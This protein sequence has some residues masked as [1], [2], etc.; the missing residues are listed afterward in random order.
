M[1][2]G[3]RA[4]KSGALVGA[5]SNYI[6]SEA[7]ESLRQAIAEAGGTEVFA[8]GRCDRDFIVTE[9]SV[10]AR[11]NLTA[12]PVVDA[13]LMHG[14]V[15]IHNHPSGKLLPSEADL[16]VAA[17]L[18]ARGVGFWIVNN[19]VSQI[20]SVTDPLA[21]QAGSIVIDPADI[22]HIFSLDG[23]LSAA[24]ED[25][26]VR[27]GQ[28]DMA[29]AVSSAF[30]DSACLVVEAGTGTGKSLAY[31]VP[32]FLWAKRNNARVVVS[33]NTINLQEQLIQKDIPALEAAIGEPLPAALVKGRGNYLCMRKLNRVLEDEESSIEPEYRDGFAQ[34]LQWAMETETGDRSDMQFEPD[35]EVWGMVCSEGDMC[36]RTKCPNY[37]Q[38]CFHRARQAMEKAEVLVVNHHILFADAFIRSQMGPE[39]DRA[40]LPRYNVVIVDE[41]HNAADVAT[42]H[43]GRRVSRVSLVRLT[44]S[45]YRR[46][47]AAAQSV[48]TASTGDYGALVR[49]RSSLYSSWPGESGRAR[50]EACLDLIHIDAIPA[51]IRVREAG[52]AFFDEVRRMLMDVPGD[53]VERTLRITGDVK[54]REDWDARIFPAHERFAAAL[55]GLAD[56][57]ERLSVLLRGDDDEALLES[58][59]RLTFEAESGSGVAADEDGV[60]LGPGF[61]EADFP[62]IVELAAYAGRAREFASSLRFAVTADAPGHVFWAEASG[63]GPRSNVRVVAA[64]IE[65][66]KAIAEHVLSMQESV[67]FTSATLAVGTSFDYIIHDLGLDL[68]D[69][70]RVRQMAIAAPFDYGRQALLAVVDDIPNP[71]SHGWEAAV[72]EA[73]ASILDASDGRAFV[74]FTS[75]KLLSEVARAVEPRLAQR[76]IAL[77]RQGNAPRHALLAEFRRDVRS[78]LFGTDS[79]WEGVDV[80][81]EALS[82]VVMPRLPFAVPTAPVVEA[83]IEHI[84]ESGGNPFSQYTLP[85]AVLKFKQGFG[86]LVRSSSDRGAVVVLD[87]RIVRRHYGRKFIDAL[88]GCAKYVG[89]FED[90]SERLY[91]WLINPSP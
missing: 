31:L 30:S 79:F 36:L 77:L 54:Q 22:R 69:G 91:E 51:V 42:Q 71:D 58:A 2:C 86:R 20:R 7:A 4:L 38:C 40:V 16:D 24:F 26:E 67:V 39:A 75:Y 76:N 85:A 81:G 83:R 78:V 13:T 63:A 84:A 45:I 44:N 23:P 60:D 17:R 29:L 35:S 5:V 53:G 50:A 74:L 21:N 88:P 15:V 32:A 41:A 89:G 65:A 33:T 70:D 52:E 56:C 49:L 27:Q 80:P 72:A 28:I 37:G 68:L 66:G 3:G 8:V 6:A 73:V 9:I 43:F 10:L 82:C 47:R 48:G 59:K 62:D 1:C 55:E 57:L 25:Y 87:S 90:V 12:A 34:V 61:D 64:P 19:D 11:G 18:A 14:Q 46:E